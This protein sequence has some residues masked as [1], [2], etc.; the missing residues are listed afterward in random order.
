[1]MTCYHILVCFSDQKL[2]LSLSC[3]V[4]GPKLR[5]LVSMTMETP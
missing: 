2:C 5:Q 3:A 1:M 4:I